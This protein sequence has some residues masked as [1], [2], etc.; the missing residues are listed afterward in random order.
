MWHFTELKP[1]LICIFLSKHWTDCGG[2]PLVPRVQPSQ[3]SLIACFWKNTFIKQSCRYTFTKVL[4]WTPDHNF[5]SDQTFN[6]YTLWL[7]FVRHAD[8]RLIKNEES[9]ALWHNKTKK[10]KIYLF[11]MGCLDCACPFPGCSNRKVS[12]SLY[13]FSHILLID[14]GLRQLWLMN[15]TECSIEKTLLQQGPIF[16]GGLCK[17]TDE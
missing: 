17:T 2:P 10:H 3:C 11:Q 1:L 6:T 8:P 9:K 7:R 16:W 4:L 14:I 5:S 13:W 12:W 15:A